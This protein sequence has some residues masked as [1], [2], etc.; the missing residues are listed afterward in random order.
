MQRYSVFLCPSDAD[1]EHTSTLI[2]ELCEKYGEHPFEPHVTVCSGGYDDLGVLKRTVS[3]AVFDIQTLSLM[4]KRV[5][6]SK[7]YF[8]SLFIEFEEN[9]MLLK[10]RERMLSGLETEPAGKYFP[11][12]S[13]LYREMPLC[14]KQELADC[15][16]LDRLSIHCNEV[17]IVTPRNQELGWRDTGQWQTLYHVRLGVDRAADEQILRL[18]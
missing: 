5:G 12:M 4:V 10:I 7:A 16:V 8:R 15:L 9:S 18:R 2:R 1:F 13:L 11:H 14:Q 17:K 6:Y 3:A